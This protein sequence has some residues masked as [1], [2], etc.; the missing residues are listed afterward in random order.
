LSRKLLAFSRRQPLNPEPVDLRR[1][2]DGMRELLDRT[3]RGDVE[4]KTELAD[5][6][7]P[8]KVDPAEW[9]LVVLNLC[10]N[11]RD[12]MPDGGVITIGAKNEPQVRQG[13]LTGDFVSISVCDTGTGMSAGVLTHIFEPFFTTKEIGKGS[14]L[15]LPQ[16]YGFTQQSGGTISVASVLGE[17]TTVTL[18][19]PRT[20]GSPAEPAP[21]RA[22]HPA[23]LNGRLGSILLVEDNDEVAMLVT[24]MLRE[25]GYRVTRAASAQGALGALADEREV[26]LVLSDIMMPGTMNGMELAREVRRRRPGAPILLTTGYAGAAVQDSEVG[27][28]EILSKPYAI[29]A[30]D[31]AL[32]VALGDRALSG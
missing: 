17:G 8:I 13:E 23:R 2:I 20:A 25:L 9:E 31:A 12:A 22:D 14:G 30:L 4:V 26:D 28:I 6:L 29:E 5:D 21:R 15:G 1:Q 7:W 3:L 19:L 11:A 18:L 16:V 24:E 32:R 10:V 27:D